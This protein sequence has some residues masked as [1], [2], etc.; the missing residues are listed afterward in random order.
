MASPS[1]GSKDKASGSIF[2]AALGCPT[3]VGIAAAIGGLIPI[4]RSLCG[5][6]RIRG[7]LK[8]EGAKCHLIITRHKALTVLLLS[9]FFRLFLNI[10]LRA[11]TKSG[12]SAVIS[13]A[14]SSLHGPELWHKMKRK[15]HDGNKPR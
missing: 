13:L 6:V 14:R 3:A 9:L 2:I 12:F 10:L 1:L 7:C 5:C 15:R 4:T 8:G 11:P